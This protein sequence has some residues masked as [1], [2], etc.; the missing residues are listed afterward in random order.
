MLLIYMSK[1]LLG[2]SARKFE[3]SQAW[4]QSFGQA[5][6]LNSIKADRVPLVLPSY[7][8]SN[9]RYEYSGYAIGGLVNW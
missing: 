7:P 6:A 9:Y 2:G 3:P 1:S 4:S 5:Q 8:L